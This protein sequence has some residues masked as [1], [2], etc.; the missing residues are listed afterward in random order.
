[1]C[2]SVQCML[3]YL[4]N[5]DSELEGRGAVCVLRLCVCVCAFLQHAH[6]HLRICVCLFASVC[7][8]ECV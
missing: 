2:V 5:Y 8:D 6:L 7:M 4:L 3:C 1:M